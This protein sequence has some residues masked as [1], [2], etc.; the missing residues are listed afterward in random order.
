M[1]SYDVIVVGAGNAGISSAVALAQQGLKPLVLE[2]HNLPGGCAGS[3]VRG[4]FEFD[5]SLH[6]MFYNELGFK[7][8]WENQMG[9]H[10]KMGVIPPGFTF[11]YFEPDGSAVREDYDM[12]PTKFVAEFEEYHPGC[13]A[14]MGKFLTACSQTMQAAAFAQSP[15]FTPQL[16]AERFPEFVKYSKMTAQQAFD[17]ME[18]PMEVQRLLGSI[19]W[20]IGPSISDYSFPRFASIWAML[21][22]MPIHYPEYTCHEYLAMMEKKVRELGGDVW[23]NTL[24]TDIVVKD[25][26][27]Q[28]VKTDKDDFIPCAQVVVNTSPRIVFEKLIKEGVPK[29]EEFLAKQKDIHENY[30]FVCVYLGLD[31]T[32]E[33]LGIKSHHLFFTDA[34]SPADTYVASGTLTGPF[35]IGGLCPNIT[36]PE[37]STEGTCVLSLS[38]GVQGFALEGLSQEQYFKE[39]RRIAHEMIESA[40]RH[41]GVNLFE[42]IEELE[43][44]TPATLS[45]YAVLRNGSLAYAQTE[46]DMAKTEAASAELN[47]A[48]GVDGLTFVGQY[49]TSIGYHNSVRGYATGAALAKNIKEGEQ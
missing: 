34:D 5:V 4:R 44:A 40:S 11:S 10:P 30:S 26:K 45:R 33:E 49:A 1:K 31:A 41:L 3:F 48:S 6:A 47:S 27:V 19:W 7:N 37:F 2:Q 12:D 25:N 8:V 42:H 43:V 17:A 22:Q 13:G 35:A 15:E 36:F 38:S 24:V 21:I 46:L 14:K 23:Y 16:M 9:I 28:G 29:R 32:A 18:L 20:Y 39:K